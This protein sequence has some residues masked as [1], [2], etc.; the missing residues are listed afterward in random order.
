LKRVDLRKG[1]AYYELNSAHHH[2][3]VVCTAC[4]EIE[5]FE[6]CGVEKLS[7]EVL[8]KS[9]KFKS[10][11]AHSLELFGVCESCSKS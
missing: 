2:H 5:G 4:G 3:H 11:S 10:V 7:K 1:S 8:A 6:L 9:K